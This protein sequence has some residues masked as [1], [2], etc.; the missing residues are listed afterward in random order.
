MQRR[1]N[2]PFPTTPQELFTWAIGRAASVVG[3]FG[4]M[5]DYLRL[6][7]WARAY[8]RDNGLTAPND[9]ESYGVYYTFDAEEVEELKAK[10]LLEEEFRV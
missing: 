10:G 4:G 8:A 6:R 9:L 5:E 7:Q 3:E 2:E 1:L